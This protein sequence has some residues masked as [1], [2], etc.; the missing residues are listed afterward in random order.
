VPAYVNVADLLKTQ[1]RDTEAEAVLREGLEQVPDA[2]PIH[3]ALGLTL[4]RLGHAEQGLTALRR[5]AELAPANVRFARVHAV[6]LHSA[7]Q[8]DAA[9]HELDRALS[10]HPDDYDLLT[11]ALIFRRDHADLVGAKRYAQQLLRQ[12]SQDAAAMQLAQQVGVTQ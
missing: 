11:T 12:H 7:G 5:A 1:G 4:V 2:A 10:S 8:F 9:M 6:A 3:H